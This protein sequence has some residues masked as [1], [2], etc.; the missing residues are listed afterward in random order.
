MSS[1][2]SVIAPAPPGLITISVPDVI[3][4]PLIFK[5]PVNPNVLP[6]K[7]KLD[8]TVPVPSPS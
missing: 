6:S 5:S 8:S 2:L 4:S 7:V 1:A 3:I